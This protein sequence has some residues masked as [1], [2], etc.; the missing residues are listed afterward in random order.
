MSVLDFLSP[1]QEPDSDKKIFQEKKAGFSC[2]LHKLFKQFYVYVL[3][4]DPLR[5]INEIVEESREELTEDF[6][7]TDCGI[8]TFVSAPEFLQK[9]RRKIK[10]DELYFVDL[11]CELVTGEHVQYFRNKL[12]KRRLRLNHWFVTTSTEKKVCLTLNF[13]SIY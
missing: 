10:N 11:E 5:K 12:N 8:E 7:L 6:I 3:M 1:E 13:Y 2:L 4:K 9:S